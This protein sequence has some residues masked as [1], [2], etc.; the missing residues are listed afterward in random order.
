[1]Q[2]RLR[3]ACRNRLTNVTLW[4][5][6]HRLLRDWDRSMALHSRC[7]VALISPLR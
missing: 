3:R 2:A 5:Y 1:M 4:P 7:A 6:S